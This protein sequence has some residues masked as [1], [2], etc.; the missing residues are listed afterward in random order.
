MNQFS[1]DIR[2]RML[3]G[4]PTDSALRRIGTEYRVCALGW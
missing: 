4:E 2:K 3:P 1:V